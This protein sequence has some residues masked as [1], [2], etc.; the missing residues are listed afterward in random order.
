VIGNFPSND[1]AVNATDTDPSPYARPVPLT[2]ADPIIGASGLD[3]FDES[4]VPVFCG[5]IA[6]IVP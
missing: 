2:V 4:V 3:L 5:L 6:V 1:G